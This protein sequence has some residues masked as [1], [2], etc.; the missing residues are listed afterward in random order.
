V[1]S[2]IGAGAGFTSGPVT[3]GGKTYTKPKFCEVFCKRLVTAGFD[4]KPHSLVFSLQGDPADYTASGGATDAGAIELPETLGDITGIRT[5]RIAN[6]TNDA[7]LLVGC[8][9]GMAF[10]SGTDATNFETRELTRSFG[11]VSN[12]TWVQIGDNIYFMATDGIRRYSNFESSAFL[13]TE[14]LSAPVHDLWARLNTSAQA[15]AFAVHHPATFE[16]QWWFPI[17]SDT[18]PKNAFIMNYNT[19]ALDQPTSSVTVR[20]IWS[21]KDGITTANCGIEYNG[22]MYTGSTDGYLQVHYSG[23]DFNGTRNNWS[24]MPALVEANTNNPGQ[25]G[26]V[27]AIHILTEGPAQ[28]F[29]ATSYVVD[30]LSTDESMW[31][32]VHTQTLSASASSVTNLNTWGSGTTTTYPKIIPYNPVGSGRYWAHRFYAAA[33]NDHINFVGI[34][35]LMTMGGLKQ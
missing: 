14:H 25:S 9:R 33:D 15:T 1:T 19:Q 34:M 5:I 24:I 8:S 11:L 22:V 3:L 13:L 26:S 20:P 17:D 31:E 4:A 35:S 16:V 10:I 28:A 27:R 18:N 29:T 21:T 32:Q 7:I 12:R 2:G 30:T 6:D 23:D